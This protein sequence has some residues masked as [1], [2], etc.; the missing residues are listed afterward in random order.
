[1]P[2]PKNP[3]D[4]MAL[5]RPREPGEHGFIY[6]MLNPSKVGGFEYKPQ[7][8]DFRNNDYI[9]PGWHAPMT[10][11]YQYYGYGGFPYLPQPTGT[12]GS[13]PLPPAG[14]PPSQTAY[15]PQ[16][17]PMTGKNPFQGQAKNAFSVS[18]IIGNLIRNF[19]AAAL[20][21]PEGTTAEQFMATWDAW[22]AT[23]YRGRRSPAAEEG[24]VPFR[25]YLQQNPPGGTQQG[26]QQMPLGWSGLINQRY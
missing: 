14:N 20:G 6:N 7:P 2:V 4:P 22:V 5:W 9:P 15:M 12:G 18:N 16:V 21:L 8:G 19:G 3:W 1:M 11:P 26:L 24:A 10:T 25:Q 17:K 23:N 13:L